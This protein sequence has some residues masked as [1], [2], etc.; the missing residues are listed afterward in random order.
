MAK[1]FRKGKGRV[2]GGPKRHYRQIAQLV[3]DRL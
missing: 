1:K 3:G 2:R